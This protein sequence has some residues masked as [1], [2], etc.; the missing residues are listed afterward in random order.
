MLEQAYRARH[1]LT[2]TIKR[3]LELQNTVRTDLQSEA[4]N[5]LRQFLRQPSAITGCQSVTSSLS[6]ILTTKLYNKLLK[7]CTAHKDGSDYVSQ[8]IFK[9]MLDEY[10]R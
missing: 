8:E 4:V 7:K 3:L 5:T 10:E 2:A 1:L 6:L 9:V